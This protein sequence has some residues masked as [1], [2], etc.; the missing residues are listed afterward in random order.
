LSRSTRVILLC[1]G[2]TAATRAARFPADEPLLEGEAG[3]AGELASSILAT[4]A[5]ILSSPAH[6]ARQTAEIFG[7]DFEVDRRLAD[8]N[9]GDWSGRA[10]S[11]IAASAPGSIKKWT[12][13]CGFVPPGGESI[14]ALLQRTADWM[15]DNLGRGGQILA[16]THRAVC[17]AA[18]VNALGAPPDAFW[19]IDID[20]PG[21]V[22]LTND[23]RRWALRQIR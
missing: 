13:E 20:A 11:D 9:V 14:V 21:L 6:C 10:L 2:S 17:R 4:G 15:A 19:K 16:V 12:T 1:H 7:Q 8:L 23:G 5:S 18:V 22:S 3:K